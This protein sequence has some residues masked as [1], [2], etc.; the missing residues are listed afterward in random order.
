[1]VDGP[2]RMSKVIPKAS[3][4]IPEDSA[5]LNTALSSNTTAAGGA[6][7]LIP[8]GAASESPRKTQLHLNGTSMQD[9]KIN[10]FRTRTSKQ[11]HQ[12]QRHEDI[13]ISFVSLKFSNHEMDQRFRAARMAKYQTRLKFGAGFTTF[14]IPLLV[15]L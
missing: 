14:F 1:M 12:P 13:G 9:L 6:F 4:T 3:N 8:G 7:N 5:E 11:V 15:L 2:T 10:F